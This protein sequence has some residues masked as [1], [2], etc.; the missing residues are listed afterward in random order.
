MART[1]VAVL[2]PPPSF[3]ELP[4]RKRDFI[5]AYV[6]TGNPL[7]A[8]VGAGYKDS[9]A[10]KR[11]AMELRR[12][13]NHYIGEAVT[14]YARSND[15]AILGLT[16]LSDLVVG[17]ASEGVKLAAAKELIRLTVPDDP[18]EVTVNHNHTVAKLSDEQID[19]RLA[20]LH[21]ELMEKDVTPE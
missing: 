4:K 6:R 20:Q 14:Q 10:A 9:P 16:A 21:Q 1:A 11:N 8:Y 18:K 19:R 7:K 12:E 13:L 17:A 2:A 5:E 3:E 15:L